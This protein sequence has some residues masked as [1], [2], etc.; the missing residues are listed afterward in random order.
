MI[1]KLFNKKTFYLSLFILITLEALIVFFAPSEAIQ[2]IA[3]KI[4]YIHL[5]SALISFIAIFVAVAFGIIYLIKK[6]LKWDTLAYRSTRIGFFFLSIVLITG[7][8]WGKLI[9][10][11]WWSWDARLTS[12]LIFWLI[13]LSYLIIRKFIE[14]PET[15]ATYCAVI[16]IFGAIDIPIIHFSVKWWRTI[17]PKAIVLTKS[18]FGISQ[19]MLTSLLLILIIHFAIYLLFMN[20]KPSPS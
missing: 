11:T 6:A 7:M 19:E 3:M 20:K 16:S 17:H 18:N 2:G 15:K 1:K 14:D 13:L 8:I 9:W 4:F 12:T 5:P 10:N